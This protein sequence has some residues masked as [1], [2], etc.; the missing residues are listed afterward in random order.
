MA[1]IL[2]IYYINILGC[3]TSCI[4]FGYVLK[5]YSVIYIPRPIPSRHEALIEMTSINYLLSLF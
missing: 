5:L 4:L 3:C 1:E 2:I